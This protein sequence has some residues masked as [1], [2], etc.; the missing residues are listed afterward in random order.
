MTSR[1]DKRCGWMGECFE[2]VSNFGERK[3]RDVWLP[4]SH[5][6]GTY[7]LSFSYRD[8][9]MPETLVNLLHSKL[10]QCTSNLILN[11]VRRYAKTQGHSILEQLIYGSRYLDLRPVVV[12]NNHVPNL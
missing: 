3:I 8:E 7:N 9:D 6:A 10:P 11:V 2:N 1:G 4:G 12:K 5:D